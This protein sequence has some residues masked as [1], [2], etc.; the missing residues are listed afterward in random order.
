[1][2][3]Q[4]IGN[5]IVALAPYVV[6]IFGIAASWAWGRN[7]VKERDG[8]IAALKAQIEVM[9]RMRPANIKADLDALHGLYGDQIKSLESQLADSE[10][11]ASELASQGERERLERERAD[12][13]ARLEDAQ[14]AQQLIAL[15][16]DLQIGY[17][18]IGVRHSV[19]VA[20]TPDR[21]ARTYDVSALLRW[22][23]LRAGRDGHS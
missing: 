16:S 20:A 14:A 5:F 18:G 11:R 12:L 7:A 10:L 4:A 15:L 2:N 1:M 8:V 17:P 21:P 3:W 6:G 13:T 19:V 22:L 23:E 9:E